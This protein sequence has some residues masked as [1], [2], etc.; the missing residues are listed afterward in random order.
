MPS[1]EEWKEL[2][3]NLGMSMEDSEKGL[4]GDIGEKLKEAGNE[5]WEHLNHYATNESGL[6][7]LL[8]GYRDSFGVFCFL[9]E[10]GSFCSS[11]V[12]EVLALWGRR[13]SANGTEVYRFFDN[14]NCSFSMRC[15]KD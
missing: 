2:E 12:E 4:R 10:L 8:G 15:I 3:K 1:D 9:H 5:H 7:V 11:S 6:T 13:F 14:E